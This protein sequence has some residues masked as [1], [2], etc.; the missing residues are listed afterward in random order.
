M[1]MYPLSLLFVYFWFSSIRNC[2][3]VLL[4]LFSVLTF[5]HRKTFNQLQFHYFC[6]FFICSRS[7]S[8]RSWF[9]LS[10]RRVGT[11]S[12]CSGSFRSGS[13]PRYSHF[14][15]CFIELVGSACRLP[16][17]LAQRSASCT[18]TH[19]PSSCKLRIRVQ[20]WPMFGWRVAKYHG[21]TSSIRCSCFVSSSILLDVYFAADWMCFRSVRRLRSSR[22]CV[23]VI[24]A[25][26][27][28]SRWL[29]SLTLFSAFC[30]GFPKLSAV[31]G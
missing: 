12:S 14:S 8:R 26:S 6:V 7:S 20:R 10:C 15:H 11:G 30:S 29:D 2:H 3:F 22:R 25:Y 16:P 24:T 13:R 5:R 4:P 17:P 27:T 31:S 23:F 1:L 21:M 9:F 18:H 19:L 28:L